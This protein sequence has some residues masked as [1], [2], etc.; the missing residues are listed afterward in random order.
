MSNVQYGAILHAGPG[1]NPDAV[2]VTADRDLRP[3]GNIILQDH[4]AQYDGA[5]IDVHASAEYRGVALETTQIHRVVVLHRNKL[6]MA[7]LLQ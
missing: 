3:H 7:R 5:G 6:V 1:A 4:P 2:H